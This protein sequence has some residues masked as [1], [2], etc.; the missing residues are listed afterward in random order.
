MSQITLPA[1]LS[2][3]RQRIQTGE[4]DASTALATQQALLE[5]HHQSWQCVTHTF[6]STPAGKPELPLAGVG[7]AHKDLFVVG[8][9]QPYAGAPYNT[10]HTG[11]Y[12]PLIRRLEQAG[13]HTMAMLSMAE[14]ACGVTGENPH[15][16]RPLNPID[17]K[18]AVGGSSSGS[19]VAVAA[20]LCYGSLGSDTAGSVR[21]PAATCGVLGL[22]PTHGVLSTAGT[23]PLAPSLD[24]IGILSRSALDAAHI[25]HV[26][27]SP[28]QQDRHFP[29]AYQ[30]AG[31]LHL[32]A[33]KSLRIASCFEH[34]RAAFTP[35][36]EQLA[37]LEQ[38]AKDYACNA[39]PTRVDLPAFAELTR[40]SEVILHVETAAQHKDKLINT[41]HPLS[42]ACRTV[43]HAGAAIPADWY[44]HAVQT[45]RQQRH[46]FIQTYFK[47]HDVLLTPVL[48]QGIP[49]WTEV[50]MLSPH[51]KPRSL[52][53]L[54]SWTSFVN[55]LGLPAIVFPI[56]TDHTGRPVSVQAIARPHAEALLLAWA[57][58][59]EQD[60]YGQ[61]GFIPQPHALMST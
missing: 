9:R 41:M 10:L 38:V 39:T 25:L 45:R 31:L 5:R 58:Q 61:H 56:G 1:T 35:S 8:Q 34:Y 52:I 43:I 57:Y 60:R 50:S 11:S 26:S 21:I 19:G 46:A 53:S 18:A 37:M 16:P 24:T 29:A 13:S 36:D 17:P 32:P 27:L 23:Y 42:D 3:L 51:F 15:W 59:V 6:H 48:P 4:L 49:D 14:Y 12:S 47:E 2:A 33:I 7:L 28:R 54:F 22:M 44:V 55:Y 30:H 20:G 40:A